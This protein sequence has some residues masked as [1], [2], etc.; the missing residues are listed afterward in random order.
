MRPLIWLHCSLAQ[1]ML[2]L[3][4]GADA[5]LL[6]A[7]ADERS[8]LAAHF[9]AFVLSH[10]NWGWELGDVVAAHPVLDPLLAQLL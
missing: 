7:N 8:F 2:L 9:H 1:T 10:G 5:Q 6:L 3:Y 4:W